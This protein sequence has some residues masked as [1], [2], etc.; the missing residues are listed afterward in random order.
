MSKKHYIGEYNK[1]ELLEELWNYATNYHNT[2]NR[3]FNLEEAKK[4]M[5]NNFPEYVCGKII[6]VDIYNTNFVDSSYFDKEN[7]EYSFEN[8]LRKLEDKKKIIIYG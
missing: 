5:K 7:G 8:V 2:L 6:M 3:T 1:D 4:E